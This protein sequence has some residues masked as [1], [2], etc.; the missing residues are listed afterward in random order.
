MIQIILVNN[1]LIREEGNYKKGNMEGELSFMP[2]KRKLKRDD[3]TN[4]N[5]NNPAKESSGGGEGG[6]SLLGQQ[7]EPTLLHSIKPPHNE[8]SNRTYNEDED[9]NSG[10]VI[11]NRSDVLNPEPTVKRRTKTKNDKIN[12]ISMDD[13]WE[14]DDILG[15]RIT[16]LGRKYKVVWKPT[17]VHK[18][19]LSNSG[20]ALKSYQR[21]VRHAKVGSPQAHSTKVKGRAAVRKGRR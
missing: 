5:F 21:R 9:G 20:D 14:I 16:R 18:S 6:D 12:K 8:A 7:A 3:I 15:E 2:R 11:N 17:W 1:L 13:E 4:Y 10:G 19:G